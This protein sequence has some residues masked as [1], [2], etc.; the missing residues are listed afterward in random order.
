MFQSYGEMSL[1]KTWNIILTMSSFFK[2][3]LRFPVLCY[4]KIF[5]YNITKRLPSAFHLTELGLAIY[6]NK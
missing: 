2:F 1:N 5:F 3:N 6:I 4:F